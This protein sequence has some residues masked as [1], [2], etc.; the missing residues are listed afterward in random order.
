MVFE[1]TMIVKNKEGLSVF[2]DAEGTVF[3]PSFK[4]V[5]QVLRM[6]LTNPFNA[7]VNFKV[8]D[9]NGQVASAE[10]KGCDQESI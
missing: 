8:Y 10:G 3:K 1:K 5:E 4:K 9:A 7:K 6:S 2:A